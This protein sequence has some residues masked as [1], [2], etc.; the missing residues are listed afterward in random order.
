VENCSVHRIPDQDELP[1]RLDFSLHQRFNKYQNK[2]CE[3]QKH[4]LSRQLVDRMIC[5]SKNSP[6]AAALVN[7]NGRVLHEQLEAFRAPDKPK[8]LSF[9]GHGLASSPPQYLDYRKLDALESYGV[10]ITPLSYNNQ[11][12]LSDLPLFGF[13]KQKLFLRKLPY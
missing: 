13:F 12:H 11:L 5:T 10:N 6:A 4:C 2:F 9:H 1:V 8:I 7:R 3:E